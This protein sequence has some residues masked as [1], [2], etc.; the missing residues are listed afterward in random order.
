MNREKWRSFYMKRG[1]YKDGRER[2]VITWYDKKGFRKLMF[3]PEPEKLKEIL[4]A[5]LKGAPILEEIKEEI[6]EEVSAP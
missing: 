2:I 4:S 6:E 5:R 3:L 1:K